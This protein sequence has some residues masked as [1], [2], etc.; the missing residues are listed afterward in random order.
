LAIS[1]PLLGIACGSDQKVANTA[2]NSPATYPGDAS[3]A[4]AAQPAGDAA[5]PNSMPNSVPPSSPASGATPQGRTESSSNNSL[6]MP[7]TTTT[8][9]PKSEL[10]ESQ[11]AMLA[12]LANTSEI[13]QGK[14]AQTKAKSPSV[15]KFAAM[16]VK[17]HTDAKNEQKKLFDSLKI[18]PMQSQNAT[19]LKNSADE[20]LSTLRGAQ[21]TDFDRTYIDGQV[22]EHQ[23]VLDLIDQQLLPA[24]TD[25]PLIDGLKKMRATVESHLTEAKNIQAELSKTSSR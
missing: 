8:S 21:P 3:T 1:L 10:S 6:G 5:P 17:H 14:L 13:E 24:A 7:G 19:T 12:D 2:E 16:M 25:Q 22:A 15:K 9:A 20:T 18:T 23:Q 4:M 11:V